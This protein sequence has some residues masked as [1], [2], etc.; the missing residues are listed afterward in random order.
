MGKALY[1]QYRSRSLDEVV[2]Q[3]H[4]TDILKQAIK[5]QKISHAYLLTGPRGVGKTSIARIMAHAINDLPYDNEDIHLDIIEIDAASNNG[6]EDVRDLREKVHVAPVSAKY[7]V[8]IIDEVHM[9]SNAAFNALLKTLEEP[10]EHTV[11]ILAT[12]ELHKVPATIISRTQ[13]FHF[14]PASVQALTAHLKMIAKKEAI[15][16][17]DEALSL[18]AERGDGS[19][20]DSISLLDQLSSL[21]DHITIE[22][23]E[24]T[25]GL[26][27]YSLVER[28]TEAVIAKDAKLIIELLQ[29]SDAH[30][31]SAVTVTE[32][33]VSRL[34]H[35]GR[36]QPQLFQLIDT[37]LGVKQSHDPLMKLTATLVAWTRP[38]K[39]S[40][41]RSAVMPTATFTAPPKP[42]KTPAKNAAPQPPAE[43]AADLV[44]APSVEQPAA[45]AGDNGA[46][47]W[48]KIMDALKSR[49]APLH[50]VIS[51]AT[52]EYAD[53]TLTLTFSYALHRKKLENATYRNQLGS[54]IAHTCG[55]SPQIVV[56]SNTA[57]KPQETELTRSVAD[58]MGGGEVVD[59]R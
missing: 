18:I 24:A 26:A 48:A 50:S 5:E 41:A 23:I 17:D 58:I 37:L 28:L 34:A 46:F 57:A 42:A 35:E 38:P 47:D 55:V 54:I 22:L 14:R 30:G 29:D 10:P 53:N 31:I 44:P 1:R 59:A 21:S 2:G 36:T 40:A 3:S 25:L 32:Q 49:H 51:R 39:N 15:A 45:P 43:P 4:V 20:R 56:T 12:T 7:K 52:M 33:L 9:L 27:P 6:V 8:Y 19:F 16:I 11:F 13:R